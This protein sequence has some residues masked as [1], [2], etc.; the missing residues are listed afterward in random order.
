MAINVPGFASFS[1]D[2]FGAAT[3]SAIALNQMVFANARAS[4]EMALRAQ[5]A[6]LDR[7]MRTEEVAMAANQAERDRIA[8]R[9]LAELRES[10]ATT[11]AGEART[12]AER[13]AGLDRQAAFDL[14]S[15]RQ[16]SATGRFNTETDLAREKFELERRLAEIQL[17]EQEGQQGLFSRNLP[18]P[19]M[20]PVLPPAPP[21]MGP[22]PPPTPGPRLS[23]Q[24]RQ[25]AGAPPA[26]E[27][28]APAAEGAVSTPPSLTGN[29]VRDE[30]L[31]RRQV[32]IDKGD[33]QGMRDALKFNE[34]IADLDAK[35]S[36]IRREEAE[37]RSTEK[38]I[39]FTDL[40]IEQSRQALSRKG[41]SDDDAKFVVDVL[42][43]S[44]LK[45]SLEE[46]TEEALQSMMDEIEKTDPDLIN[47]FF[48]EPGTNLDRLLNAG[49]FNLVKRLITK[50][51]GRVIN[52]TESGVAGALLMDNQA[53][54]QS[55]ND[56]FRIG[57][58]G[59]IKPTG[60]TTKRI[61]SLFELRLPG[62]DS[63]RATKETAP[64]DD[65]DARALGEIFNVLGED[66][67]DFLSPAESK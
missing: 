57:K 52:G 62:K 11:R 25:R 45:R 23:P 24:A 44:E 55:L 9:E 61:R 12:S 64:A 2:D 20:S 31:T 30:L 5:L 21:E 22:P 14:E 4:R 39:E 53:F 47:E 10:G 17:K 59:A 65:A 38:S 37:T 27:Q 26:P 48:G 54:F 15:L 66:P 16:E 51:A 49:R 42:T 67:A 13:Q 18:P 1:G 40:Q 63:N 58:D 8:S 46:R 7:K 28:A 41:F 60:R 33:E 35:E 32:A 3:R 19:S 34:M 50:T 6:R 29:P 36:K 56:N 43:K